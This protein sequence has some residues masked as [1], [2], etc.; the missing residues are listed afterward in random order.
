MKQS[1]DDADF[2][3][4]L[5]RPRPR[6]QGDIEAFR[7]QPSAAFS[8]LRSSIDQV[9][10]GRLALDADLVPELWL[11]NSNFKIAPAV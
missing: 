2:A 9:A 8:L 10:Q 5:P 1:A 4:T 6:A 3:D 11:L 7:R